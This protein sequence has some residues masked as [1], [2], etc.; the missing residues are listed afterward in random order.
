MDVGLLL[1]GTASRRFYPQLTHFPWCRLSAS[2]WPRWATSLVG[3]HPSQPNTKLLPRP[4]QPSFG[5]LC[6]DG[7]FCEGRLTTASVA[8]VYHINVYL[9][10]ALF[11]AT[12]EM[13]R[14]ADGS[15]ARL[16]TLISTGLVQNK[17]HD[18]QGISFL[19]SVQCTFYLHLGVIWN[20]L[21]CRKSR[22]LN[23][24]VHS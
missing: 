10:C 6:I 16:Q 3:D 15:D 14:V 12:S 22:V 23:S 21:A 17:C 2:C 13:A 18:A 19:H 8:L 7:H 1:H 5:F 20:A 11:T 24:G 9:G 4:A